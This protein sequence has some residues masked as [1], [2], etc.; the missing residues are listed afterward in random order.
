[1]TEATRLVKHRRRVGV[2]LVIVVAGL[3]ALAAWITQEL[4]APAGQDAPVRVD[5]ADPV[6][7]AEALAGARDWLNHKEPDKAERILRAVLADAPAEHD[8]QALLAETMLAKGK[9]QDAY[10]AFQAAIATGD[11]SAPLHFS[12]G[13]VASELG[14]PEEAEQHFLFAQ[15]LDAGNPQYPLYL[16]AVERSLNK[17]EAAK[18]A[19]LR[20]VKLKPDLAEAWGQLADI[21]LQENKLSL[22]RQHIR[23]ARQ[24]QPGAVVWRL[25]EARIL[26]RDN[27]PEEAARLLMALKRDEILD[28]PAVLEELARCYGMLRRPGEAAQLYADAV[29]R[30]PDDAALLR[31]T[32]LW[33]ERA[34]VNDAAM[35]YASRAA[36]LGDEASARLLE[37]LQRKSQPAAPPK[38]KSQSKERDK[39][40]NVLPDRV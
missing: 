13:V 20:A 9:L 29:E 3:V 31:E 16:A 17:L 6:R 2:A 15:Q 35:V 24:A 33:Y 38:D 36:R 26:R 32:A 34:G 1:M 27:A 22:A 37:R 4:R 7:I 25:V 21:A 40:E 14:K 19:L 30:R 5:A 18:V 28:N 11:P 23:R 8:A 39:H 10:T 12:T